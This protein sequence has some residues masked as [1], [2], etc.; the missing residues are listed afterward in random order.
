MKTKQIQTISKYDVSFLISDIIAKGSIFSVLFTK[1]P[2]KGETV[3]E[4]RKMV[5][6]KGVTAGLAQNPKRPRPSMPSNY[7]TVYEMKTN[8][9]DCGYKQF[10]LETL[11]TI[12]ANGVK[13]MV[14]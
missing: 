12:C 14:A 9:S 2:A 3:G 4:E 1:K 6:R 11:K 8:K 13:F 10:N 5:C 7:I